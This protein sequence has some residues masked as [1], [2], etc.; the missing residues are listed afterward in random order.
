[1]WTLGPSLEVHKF[2]PGPARTRGFGAPGPAAGAPRFPTFLIL[3]MIEI[4]TTTPDKMLQV[5]K[6]R[7]QATLGRGRCRLIPHR[8]DRHRQQGRC[9]D[10]VIEART[11]TRKAHCRMESYSNAICLIA[12]TTPSVAVKL[13]Q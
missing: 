3:S 4:F 11:R 10:A 6:Y 2:R 7:L 9:V 5:Y 13:G 1:M 8:E 12:S